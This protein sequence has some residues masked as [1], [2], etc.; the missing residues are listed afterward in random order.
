M[1]DDFHNDL[2]D[3]DMRHDEEY[4][5]PKK[6][7][8][9]DRECLSTLTWMLLLNASSLII[10]LVAVIL[11]VAYGGTDSYIRFGPG[12]EEYPLVVLS[13]NIDSGAKYAGT[14]LILVL[15]AVCDVVISQTAMVT[16]YNNIYN[17]SVTNVT[18]FS[19][20][21]SLQLYAQTMYSINAI[22]YIL[23]V[24]ISVTQ[25]DLA[26]ITAAASQLVSIKT[27]YMNLKKK[28]FN[29]EKLNIGYK[30]QVH[31][32]LLFGKRYSHL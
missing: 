2:Y 12:N 14:V 29:K 26:L 20:Q 9:K 3:D 27:I 30:H 8:R 22:R 11:G 17:V 4:E 32:N 15:L 6:S 19:S 21:T 13:V 5:E 31:P 28:T 1:N 23:S 18:D 25:I 10:M 7:R 24:K 16:I